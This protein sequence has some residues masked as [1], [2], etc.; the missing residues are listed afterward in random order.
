MVCISKVNSE[1]RI[2]Y[3]SFASSQTRYLTSWQLAPYL[4]SQVL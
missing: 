1:S 3:A 2:E 4:T